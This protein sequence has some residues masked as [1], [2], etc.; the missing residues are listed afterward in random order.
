M[1][2]TTSKIIAWMWEYMDVEETV[3]LCEGTDLHPCGKC[4]ESG[5]WCSNMMTHKSSGFLKTEGSFK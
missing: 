3:G 1:K 5:L 2:G 4:S